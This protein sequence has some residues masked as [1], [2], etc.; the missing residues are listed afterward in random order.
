MTPSGPPSTSTT[1]SAS[2]ALATRRSALGP[3]AEVAHAIAADA[4][5]FNRIP[6]FHVGLS[7]AEITPMTGPSRDLLDTESQTLRRVLLTT[8]W[9]GVC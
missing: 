8:L 2:R 6:L 5:A 1:R 9:T 3:A 7:R 4:E